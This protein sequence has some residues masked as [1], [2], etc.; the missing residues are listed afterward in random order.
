MA[1]NPLV[2]KDHKKSGEVITHNRKAEVINR[3]IYNNCI[4]KLNIITI[5]ISIKSQKDT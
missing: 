1:K 5:T 4:C 3:V 2:S